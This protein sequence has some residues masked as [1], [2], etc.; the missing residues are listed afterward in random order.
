MVLD[1]NGIELYWEATGEGEPLLWLHGGMGCG[2]DWQYIF[3]AP[4]AGPGDSTAFLRVDGERRGDDSDA[5]TS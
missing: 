5:G 1:V 2:A 3:R 4:P